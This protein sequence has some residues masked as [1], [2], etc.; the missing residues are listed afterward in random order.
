MAEF[1]SL[2]SLLS[3]C[4]TAS[5]CALSSLPRRRSSVSFCHSSSLHLRSVR[6]RSSSASDCLRNSATC[7]SCCE[8]RSWIFACSAF[9]SSPSCSSIS[10]PLLL[11]RLSKLSLCACICRAL[12]SRSASSSSSCRRR[13][14]LS[15]AHSSRMTSS[16]AACKLRS[17]RAPSSATASSTSFSSSRRRFRTS[18]A[19][20]VRISATLTLL[21]A[22]IRC[23][24]G[25][26]A[27]TACSLMAPT[28]FLAKSRRRLSSALFQLLCALSSS[29]LSRLRTASRSRGRSAMSLLSA[30][31]KAWNLENSS[32]L[33]ASRLPLM[34]PLFCIASVWLF[35][36]FCSFSA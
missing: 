5:P 13:A 30:C 4:F 20:A 10:R 25:S 35:R 21:L 9:L 34:M 17:T 3:R 16:E 36:S 28:R 12:S 22:T 6:R 8:T 14:S 33:L 7:I 31:C 18:S 23:S 11:H 27:L 26:K 24:S 2:S 1:V 19:C 15:R 29:A 32:P